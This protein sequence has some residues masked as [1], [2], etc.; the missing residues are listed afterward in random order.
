MS[1]DN[2]AYEVQQHADKLFPN[3]TPTSMFLKL[4]SEVGELVE[5][6]TEEEYADVMIMLLDYGSKQMFDIEGAIR[7]KMAINDKRVWITNDL[8]VNR[9]AE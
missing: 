3:R 6:Q 2:F 9:H 1:I 4:F 8:G 7:K 5:S